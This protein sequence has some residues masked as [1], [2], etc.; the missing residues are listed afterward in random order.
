[1][2]RVFFRGDIF[3]LN[4]TILFN[5]RM[6]SHVTNKSKYCIFKWPKQPLYVMI[7]LV[8]FYINQLLLQFILLTIAITIALNYHAINVCTYKVRTLEYFAQFIL[9]ISWY[10]ITLIWIPLYLCLPCGNTVVWRPI[11]FFKSII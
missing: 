1:M 7:Y 9:K 2:F 6:K 11:A 8:L 4:L 10:L 3:S 5:I